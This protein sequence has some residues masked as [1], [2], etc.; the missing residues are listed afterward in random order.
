MKT[1]D[2]EG[3][4]PANEALAECRARLAAVEKAFMEAENRAQ[5]YVQEHKKL[6][7]LQ[8]L[9]QNS[10][11]RLQEDYESLRVQKGGFGFKML[12]ASGM[13][14]TVAGAVLCF[15]FFRPTD[16][17]ART[18]EHFRRDHL[19]SIEYALSEG[20]FDQVEKKLHDQGDLPQY[21][22]IYPE[23]EMLRKVVTASKR[24]CRPGTSGSDAGR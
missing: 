1:A 23:I 5:K 17:R 9:H 19:F 24:G 2:N 21:Q 18:M 13:A 22:L 20:R 12:L 14:G 10:F 8:H 4:A 16:R 11:N 15:L 7:E 3:T 6:S